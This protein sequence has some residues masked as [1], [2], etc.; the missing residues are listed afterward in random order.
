M[1]KDPKK[2]GADSVVLPP[3]NKN[4]RPAQKLAYVVMAHLDAVASDQFAADD[5]EL[6]NELKAIVEEVQRGR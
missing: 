5:G 2:A 4:V 1:S 3:T 6:W